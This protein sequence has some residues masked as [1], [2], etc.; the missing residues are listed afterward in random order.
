VLSGRASGLRPSSELPTF[1][2]LYQP[3]VARH[4]SQ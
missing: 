1:P 4:L 3:I 2:R